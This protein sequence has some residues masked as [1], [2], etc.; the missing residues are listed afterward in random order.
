MSELLQN[1]GM[2]DAF[3]G[4]KADFSALGS[5][6]GYN[7]YINRVIHKTYISVFEKGTKAGAATVIEMSK[8]TSMDRPEPKYVILDRP[9]VYMIIDCEADIPVFMGTLTDIK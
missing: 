4:E 5:Y 8:N 9:F 6:D 7:I 1:M 2:T 3:D